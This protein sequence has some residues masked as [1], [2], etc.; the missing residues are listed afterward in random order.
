[1]TF[2]LTKMPYL[3]HNKRQKVCLHHV[4]I[5]L[6]TT[7]LLCAQ[8]FRQNNAFAVQFWCLSNQGGDTRIP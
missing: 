5:R 4:W 8:E 2:K 7:Y 3:S 6:I 1:M